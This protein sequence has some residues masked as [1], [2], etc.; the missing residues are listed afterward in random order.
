MKKALFWGFIFLIFYTCVYYLAKI[1]FEKKTT[2]KTIQN[3]CKQNTCLI[4]LNSCKSCNQKSECQK[5]IKQASLVCEKC[6]IELKHKKRNFLLCNPLAK[7]EYSI[8][9]NFCNNRFNSSGICQQIDENLVCVCSSMNFAKTKPKKKTTTIQNAKSTYKFT[10]SVSNFQNRTGS[11]FVSSKTSTLR[12]FFDKHL[13]ESFKT[14]FLDNLTQEFSTIS[15]ASTKSTLVKKLTSPN[16]TNL[17][18]IFETLNFQSSRRN[19]TAGNSSRFFYETISTFKND[20]ENSENSLNITTDF[21]ENQTTTIKSNN[22]I[23]TLLKPIFNHK[24]EQNL[25]TESST[26]FSSLKTIPFD[27]KESI[28][29]DI[30]IITSVINNSTLITDK[31]LDN[32]NTIDTNKSIFNTEILQ[33]TESSV[34]SDSSKSQISFTSEEILKNFRNNSILPIDIYANQDIS[35]NSTKKYEH[36]PKIDFNLTEI[37]KNDTNS[38][39]NDTYFSFIINFETT[40]KI[41]TEI[42]ITEDKSLKEDDSMNT[43][44]SPINTSTNLL[45]RI[46]SNINQ[47]EPTE[48]ITQLSSITPTSSLLTLENTKINSEDKKKTNLLTKTLDDYI[49]TEETIKLETNPILSTNIETTTQL[50]LVNNSLNNFILDFNSNSSDTLDLIKENSTNNFETIIYILESSTK[51]SQLKYQSDPETTKE[52]INITNS[53]TERSTKASETTR[54]LKDTQTTWANSSNIE[55]TE[56][57]SSDND[58]LLLN[59]EKS[60]TVAKTS[61]ENSEDI[62]KSTFTQTVSSMP[63]DP[64]I[65]Y[66]STLTS[67]TDLTYTNLSTTKTSATIEPGKETKIFV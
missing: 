46:S 27:S 34:F 39:I 67:F 63:F 11:I 8:C 25:T 44:N 3:K 18:N 30:K 55:T 14:S 28:T 32:T 61:I 22:T 2:I 33:S 15:E 64:F 29:K 41:G 42:D 24:I 54:W 17:E 58:I 65:L 59:S 36:I 49:T 13:T 47:Y 6:S 57:I 51:V 40:Y 35:N 4:T 52:N 19:S 45:S 38:S 37:P 5:C 10:T 16:S 48:T 66:N 50:M 62:L 56:K 26:I 43:S 60:E 21:N 1:F 20:F 31:I 23:T 12:T 9:Q 7:L 53:T